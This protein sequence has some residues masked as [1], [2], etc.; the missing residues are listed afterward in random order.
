MVNGK[1]EIV[2]EL[3]DGS[4]RDRLKD[5]AKAGL[6]GIPVSELIQYFREAAAAKEYSLSAYRGACYELGEFE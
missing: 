4:L 2:M 6:T 1:L 3:A 5:C